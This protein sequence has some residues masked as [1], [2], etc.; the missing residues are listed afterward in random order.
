MSNN[1]AL[2]AQRRDGRFIALQF[3]YAWSMNKPDN[4]ANDW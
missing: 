2:F 4:L 3:L 1:K